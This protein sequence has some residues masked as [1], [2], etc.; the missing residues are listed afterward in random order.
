VSFTKR[1]LALLRDASNAA[2][3]KQTWGADNKQADESAAAAVK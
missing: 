2:A 1:L 3:I